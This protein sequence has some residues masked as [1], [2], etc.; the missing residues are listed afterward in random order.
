MSA[1]NVYFNGV[2]VNDG[3][4][5]GTK[6]YSCGQP[7]P[8]FALI[9]EKDLSFLQGDEGYLG[10]TVALPE[11]V[12]NE[13]RIKVIADGEEAVIDTYHLNCGYEFVFEDGSVLDISFAGYTGEDTAELE[14]YIS[15]A[16]DRE[17]HVKI[18]Y[19]GMI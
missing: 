1:G 5:N 16:A 13:C 15:T 6:I 3:Y 14:F 2:K 19:M 17:R 8:N 10:E 7:P 4:F 18:Y 11:F 12:Y 9:Y